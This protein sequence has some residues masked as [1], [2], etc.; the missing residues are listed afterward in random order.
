MTGS[1]V[2]LGAG[3][4][5]LVAAKLIARRTR[6]EVTL[7]NDRDRFVERVRLHQLAAGQHLPERPLADLL[8]GT[9]IRLVV[10]RAVGL[11]PERGTVR[12][13][14]DGRILRY[15]HL[16]YALGSREDLG[17]VPGAA[18][19]AYS[20]AGRVQTERLRDRLRTAR[21]VAVV[22]GGLTGLEAVAELA[23]SRPDLRVDLVT[24]GRLGA[25]LS[26]RGRAHLRRVLG[27]LRVGVH[28][29]V[30][31]AEVRADGL[32]LE[33]GGT[34]AADTVVWTTGF[35]VSP[36]AREAGLA[37]DGDGRV[38]VDS[39][40]RSA[41]HPRV[42][43]VGDA[44]AGVAA[45]G[46]RLRMACATGIPSAQRAAHAIA[47]RLAGREPRHLRFRYFNQCVSLGRK[48]ALIQFV[49]ADDSPREAVL[50][51]RAA[52][53]YKEAIVRGAFLAQRHPGIPATWGTAPAP[54]A[55]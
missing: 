36:M 52:V 48:D 27:R 2:V 25:A 7:V 19:Y 13:E 45:D 46:T 53:V 17:V 34:V 41:S 35:R 38:V 4:T 6:A 14:R 44:A 10:D 12:L 29:G 55:S 26:A 42:Y 50:T 43:A 33:G 30:R 49:H 18:R 54:Q 11:D 3:Y 51:G 23:E 39:T 20:V 22:G 28:D 16:V 21:G 15:D 47:D 1:V 40:L 31:V 24:G 9:G 32:A 8:K 37:V 5:G